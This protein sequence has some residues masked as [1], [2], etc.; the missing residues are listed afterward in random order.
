M[1]SERYEELMAN[2]KSDTALLSASDVIE[3]LD[4]IARLTWEVEAWEKAVEL[5]RIAA[6][7]LSILVKARAIQSACNSIIAR[8]R[9]LAQEG[10]RNAK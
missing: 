9:Q 6:G 2:S 3:C 8:Q 1:T 4:E 5:E 7:G 10:A